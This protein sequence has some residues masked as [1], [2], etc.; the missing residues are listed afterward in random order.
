LEAN[1]YFGHF[2]VSKTGC[3]FIFRA[4][5]DPCGME[6]NFSR[7]RR[8]VLAEKIFSADDLVPESAPEFFFGTF[9]FEKNGHLRLARHCQWRI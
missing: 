4:I 9:S 6:N 1:F 3:F 8:F 7:L 2:L 5:L